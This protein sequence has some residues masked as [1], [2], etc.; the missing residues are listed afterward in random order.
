MSR[1]TD[2][3]NLVIPKDCNNAPRKQIV[4]DFILAVLTGQT[5]SIQSYTSDSIQWH[6]I[7]QNKVLNGPDELTEWVLNEKKHVIGLEVYQVI[8]H[9]K[10]ASINGVTTFKK[11]NHMEFSYVLTFSSAAKSAKI[12]DVKSYEI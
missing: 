10:F 6:Q 7:N 5:A 8:T 9:G 12:V 2:K 4:L 3:L 1:N 11:S